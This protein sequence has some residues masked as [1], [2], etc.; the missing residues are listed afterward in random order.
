MIQGEGVIQEEPRL[1]YSD[2]KLINAMHDNFHYSDHFVLFPYTSETDLQEEIEIA[3]ELIRDI[4]GLGLIIRGIDTGK[5]H[6][7]NIVT[8]GFLDERNPSIST[9]KI[10]VSYHFPDNNGTQLVINHCSPGS[11]PITFNSEYLD[12]GLDIHGIL[13]PTYEH[14]QLEM[15]KSR[16]Q[17]GFR[18]V[19]R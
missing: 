6:K 3:S 5:K 11:E 17:V 1:Y 2:N 8:A 13:G 15:E 14:I 9:Y 7:Q 19:Y 4:N 12:K 10:M 18:E 16:D